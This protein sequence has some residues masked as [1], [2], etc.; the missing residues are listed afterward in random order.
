MALVAGLLASSCFNKR[1][2]TIGNFKVN[3]KSNVFRAGTGE[4]DELGGGEPAPSVNFAAS[5][6]NVLTFTSVTGRISCCSGGDEFN[7]ADGGTFAGGVTNV[8]S[9]GGISGITHPNK[10]MFLV[11]VFTD[12]TAPTAPGPARLDATSD[13]N[14]SPALF[15][16]FFIGTG[17]GRVIEVPSTATRLYLGFADAS[18]FNGPP[19]AY[20]D[21][22]GELTVAFSIGSKTK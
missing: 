19:G 8:E 22:V 13:K 10:T 7:D 12:N 6:G 16:T 17:K 5:A 15:Q 14:L 3:A 9:A 21:N 18:A 4:K 20:D 2:P 11:G 1:T